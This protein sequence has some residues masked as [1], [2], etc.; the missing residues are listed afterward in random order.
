MRECIS[1]DWYTFPGDHRCPHDA[2]VEAITVSEPF[3]GERKAQRSLEI[4]VRLLGSYHDGVIE[5]TYR[6]VQ[7][8]VIRAGHDAA[9][10]GDW[11]EDKVDI[12]EQNTLRH[13]VRLTNGSFEIQANEAVYKWT[14]LLKS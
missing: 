9:G 5:F 12:G 7:R 1:S 6:G 10:H 13:S 3:F 11:L 8:Y 14:P 2:W 4:H